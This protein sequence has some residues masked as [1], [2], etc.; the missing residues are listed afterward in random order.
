MTPPLTHLACLGSFRP[1]PLILSTSGQLG[2][3]KVDKRG[4]TEQQPFSFITDDRAEARAKRQ[5]MLQQP[6]K[7]QWERQTVSDNETREKPGKNRPGK[8][9]ASLSCSLVRK[10]IAARPPRTFGSLSSAFASLCLLGVP[11]HFPGPLR[12]IHPAHHGCCRWKGRCLPVFMC[13]LG[14]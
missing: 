13:F 4:T 9:C 1:S 5:A 14:A 2:V 6:A 10:H 12:S 8:T 11:M 3:P 7:T